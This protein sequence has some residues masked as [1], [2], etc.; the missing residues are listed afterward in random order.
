MGRHTTTK[1]RVERGAPELKTSVQAPAVAITT[2][3]VNREVADKAQIYRPCLDGLVPW[4][5]GNQSCLDLMNSLIILSRL[6]NPP[7]TF[8]YL[9]M[10]GGAVEMIEF[11]P[12]TLRPS[13]HESH[14][15]AA[16]RESHG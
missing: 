3:G 11:P 1:G 16:A 8:E 4:I 13:T 9:S 5:L 10:I 12:F 7:F 15:S 14:F 2:P 6:L